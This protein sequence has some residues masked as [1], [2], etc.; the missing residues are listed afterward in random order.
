MCDLLCFIACNCNGRSETCY[1]DEA[2]YSHTGHGGHCTDCSGNTDGANCERC[3]E[4]FYRVSDND[5]CLPCHCHQLGKFLS[6]PTPF[7]F[8][9]SVLSALTYIVLWS[10]IL[11]RF[12][13]IFM[14]FKIKY[15][16]IVDK[17]VKSLSFTVLQ[18]FDSITQQVFLKES[19]KDKCYG[20]VY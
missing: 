14:V 13:L 15:C 10:F 19:L 1:F 7:F 11:V 16:I 17:L 4:G 5:D 12:G 18:V 20:C 6:S 2:L 8:Y 9:S 3:R